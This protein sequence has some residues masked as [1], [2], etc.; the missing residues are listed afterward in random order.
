MRSFANLLAYTVQP[1]GSRREAQ[2]AIADQ[3][4]TGDEVVAY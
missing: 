4:V 2:S 3:R 1:P